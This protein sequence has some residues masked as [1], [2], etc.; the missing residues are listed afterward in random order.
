MLMQQGIRWL[1][2]QRRL[3]DEIEGR[4]AIDALRLEIAEKVDLEEPTENLLD[5]VR[6]KFDLDRSI[7]WETA[8][9]MVEDELQEISRVDAGK[10]G[11]GN[12]V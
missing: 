5:R 8:V 4:I 3:D 2:I 6:E 1:R 10:L 12:N 11:N 7:S 9:K